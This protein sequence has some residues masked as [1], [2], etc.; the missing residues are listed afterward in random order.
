MNGVE[1]GDTSP[2]VC[3]LIELSVRTLLERGEQLTRKGEKIV[4]PFG[5]AFAD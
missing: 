4:E 5:L 2:R 1:V 3:H